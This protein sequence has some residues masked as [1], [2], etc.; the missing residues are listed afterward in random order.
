MLE[1]PLVGYLPMGTGNGMGYVIGC[2]M[3]KSRFQRDKDKKINGGDKNRGSKST[4]LLKSFLS[5]IGRLVRRHQRRLEKTRQVM[6]RLKEI[7]DAIQSL[8]RM[9]GSVR[10]CNNINALEETLSGKCTIVEMPLM[11]VTYH[12]KDIPILINNLNGSAINIIDQEIDNKNKQHDKGDLCFFAG[13]GFDSLML[14]DFQQLKTWSAS[15]RNAPSFIKDALSSVAGYCVALIT[16]T[17]PQ[18]LRYGTHK[19]H[20]EVTTS[21]EGTLWVDHRRGD[22][23]EI[24]VNTYRGSA[25]GKL[26]MGFNRSESEEQSRSHE[27]TH[28]YINQQEQPRSDGI[29]NTKSHSQQQKQQHLLYSGTT[30]ILAASTTPYYGG[31]L[32][33]FPYARLI[34]NKLQLRL[35][36]ISPLT[37]FFNIP[38]IFEGSYREKSEDRFGCLDFIG[39]D[40]EVEVRSGRYEEYLRRRGE[41]LKGRKWLWKKKID[42]ECDTEEEERTKTDG[43]YSI[44]STGKGFPFQHSGESMG[45]KERFRLRVV[46][47]PVKFISFLGPRVIVD[48]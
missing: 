36:R 24:A 11:E 6:I 32:R 40:F 41:R 23:S 4:S 42:E 7:G 15:S 31:G 45:C 18:T 37:G 46:K 14:H 3:P 2:R 33:L 8:E 19:I 43:N 30:G 47:E 35:G 16:R 10:S 12:S 34:P 26:Q 13:V 38:K 17:L 48:D 25:V 5:R 27:N 28:E 44:L 20:V 1:M 9:H 21:D 22:F 39:E 29:N